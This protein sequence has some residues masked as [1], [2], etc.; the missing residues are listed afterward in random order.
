MANGGN[1]AKSG[2]IFFT[3]KDGES[4]EIDAMGNRDN[5]DAIQAKVVL[6]P[7]SNRVRPPGRNDC[8][9]SIGQRRR[10]ILADRGPP[11]DKRHIPAVILPV[12]VGDASTAG[13]FGNGSVERR[14]MAYF[15]RGNLFRTSSFEERIVRESGAAMQLGETR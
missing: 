2:E 8:T 6:A 10:I 13:I 7:S 12:V 11:Q 15:R 9:V 4:V 14:K 3:F 5:N 1:M